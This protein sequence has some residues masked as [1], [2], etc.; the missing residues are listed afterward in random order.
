VAGTIATGI[1]YS[2][3]LGRMVY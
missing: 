3:R 2:A 1:N